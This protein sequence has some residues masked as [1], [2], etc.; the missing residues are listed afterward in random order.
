MRRS[1]EGPRGRPLVVIATDWQ[2]TEDCD[3]GAVGKVASDLTF[4]TF[5][6]PE[7]PQRHSSGVHWVEPTPKDNGSRKVRFLIQMAGHLVG[8]RLRLTLYSRFDPRAQRAL[9]V[10]GIV[11]VIDAVGMRGTL[12][13]LAPEAETAF[14]AEGSDR[15]RALEK[16]GNVEIVEECSR[17]ALARRKVSA[18]DVSAVVSRVQE[19]GHYLKGRGVR[20]DPGSL[21]ASMELVATA[22]RLLPAETPMDL[23][24]NLAEVLSPDD[25]SAPFLKAIVFEGYLTQGERV[26]APMI[27]LVAGTALSAADAY[28]QSGDIVRAG[29][30]TDAALR[31][32]FHRDLHA[33]SL[34]SPLITDC[35]FLR[36]FTQSAIGKFLA[37][38]SRNRP[39]EV[40]IGSVTTRV[41]FLVGSYP[42]FGA[43]LVKALRAHRG[44][45]LDA[46]DPGAIHPALR[47][48]GPN[49]QVLDWLLGERAELSEPIEALG[50]RLKYSDVIFAD[51]ADRAAAVT[52]RLVPSGTRFIVRVH[53]MDA[54]SPWLH[55][56]DWRAVTD[57]V[58]VSEPFAR[59]LR[60]LLGDR[61]DGTRL[62]VIGNT[63][64]YADITGASAENRYTL[65][66]IGWG[67]KVKDPM[68]ALKVLAGLRRLDSR[69]RLILVGPDFAPDPGGLTAQYVSEFRSRA[70]EDDVRDAIIYVGETSTVAEYATRMDY[71]LSTSRRESFHLGLLEGVIAGAV[72]VVR[73]WPMLAEF[74][75]ARALFPTEWVVESVDEMVSLI[76]HLNKGERMAAANAAQGELLA[77]FPSGA[78]LT[79]LV[80]L[81]T[82]GGSSGTSVH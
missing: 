68:F 14:G 21:D 82:R 69:W 49:R 3:L 2:A 46:I 62:H 60:R 59:A 37:G 16:R 1:T 45:E 66:M 75:G 77:R 48:L 76:H 79:E 56:I 13:A 54:L 4:L 33:D 41:A 5:R 71:C 72:P 80:D 6:R 24:R 15:L 78:A 32:L 47:Y 42:R 61:L 19:L 11:L 55:M 63:L 29:R 8:S 26:P 9:R 17:T 65:G 34:S 20:C 67:K 51:W 27:S 31:L 38:P 70:L 58:V 35:N 74:G 44:I 10:A 30:V 53:S 50:E 25:L 22:S 7:P 18:A 28:L 73:D 57:V 43:A 52:S 64:E 40:A 81:V 36:S 23:A 39:P 12:A